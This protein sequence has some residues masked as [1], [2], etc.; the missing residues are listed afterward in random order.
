MP[1]QSDQPQR[2]SAPFTGL[3]AMRLE[4]STLR[5][6]APTIKRVSEKPAY[7]AEPLQD[8]NGPRPERLSEIPFG[9]G[10]ATCYTYTVRMDINI[11]L[12]AVGRSPQVGSRRETYGPP[13]SAFPIV[14]IAQ[15]SVISIERLEKSNPVDQ[16][17]A[18]R[19]PQLDP[20]SQS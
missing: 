8:S 6:G 5:N 17:L 18:L 4:H 11:S 20:L 10:R 12:A 13:C 14:I 19:N 15:Y 2:L 16:K 7:V 3:T 1:G 9:F